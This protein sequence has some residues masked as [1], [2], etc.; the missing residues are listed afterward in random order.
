MPRYVAARAALDRESMPD[1]II[2]ATSDSELDDARALMRDFVAW[3]RARHVEDIALINRYFDHKA[4]ETELAGLPGKYAPPHGALL[5]AYQDGQPAGC[6]AL[7]NLGV[8]IC[9]MKRMFVAEGFRELGIG[10]ALTARVIAEAKH[11]GY[12]AMRL[13]TSKRQSEAIRLY[14][15]AGFR[16][17]EPY[18]TMGDDLRDW[19]VFFELE[20][21]A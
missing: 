11:A 10:R 18:Y 20:L 14:E 6:V 12:R 15:R 21:G 9:E 3:H 17:I 13:D 16:R 7:R 1:G 19:L 8:G 2:V 4:F 5:L